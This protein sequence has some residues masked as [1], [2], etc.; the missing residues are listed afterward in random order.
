MEIRKIDENDVLIDTLIKLSVDWEN[1]H[2]TEGYISN[3]KDTF[4][5]T[6]IY[7]VLIDDEVIGYLY[8]YFRKSPVSNSVQKI[9]DRIFEIEELYIVPKY[10][11]MGYGK[12]LYKYVEEEVK[13]KVDL[14]LLSTATKDYKRI[15]HFYIDELDMTFWNAR[16]YKRKN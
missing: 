2:N 8:G 16:L 12:K 3:S 7:V 14:I 6:E 11:N 15:L 13:D 9:D 10:R 4:K 5:N 1:E